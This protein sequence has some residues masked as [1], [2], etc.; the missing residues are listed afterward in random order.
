MKDNAN[1][2]FKIKQWPKIKISC[3][4]KLDQEDLWPL[5]NVASRETAHIK[6]LYQTQSA[7]N[8]HAIRFIPI[9]SSVHS[10]QNTVDMSVYSDLRSAMPEGAS[11]IRVPR[12]EQFKKMS[13]NM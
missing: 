13:V 10:E 3:N 5:K 1:S 4:G 6:V 12:S 2:E 11:R 7:D 8:V 9:K